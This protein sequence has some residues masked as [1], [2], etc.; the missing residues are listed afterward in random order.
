MGWVSGIAVFLMAWWITLFTI[1]PWGV[2]R[3][4]NPIE[5]NEPGAPVRPDLKRKFLVTTVLAVLIWVVIYLLV[6][7]E[8]LSFHEMASNMTRKDDF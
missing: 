8:Y 5:G 6:E 3:E 4:E 1:L 2:K 7:S